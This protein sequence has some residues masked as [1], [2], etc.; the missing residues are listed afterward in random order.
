MM[1]HIYFC[2]IQFLVFYNL[3]FI[4]VEA[5]EC[6]SSGTI[7]GTSPPNGQ[8]NTAYGA[9]CCEQDK[10]YDIFTCSPPLSGATTA[11]LTLNSFEDNGDGGAP[12]ECDQKY[13]SNETPVVALSTGW[14]NNMSRCNK[15]IVIY[16]NG[17]SVTAVVVDECDSTTGC[18]QDHAYQPPCDDNIVDASEAVWTALGV[19]RSEWGSM[20]ISWSDDA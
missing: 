19:P 6:Q 3:S 16:G 13:H 10:I 14:F 7:A 4:S 18:D 11:T 15:N 17:M 2:L 5:Q 20:Q 12:S 9:A 8:C 1:K